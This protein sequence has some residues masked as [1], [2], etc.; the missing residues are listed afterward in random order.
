MYLRAYT[1]MAMH[2]MGVYLMGM[3]LKGVTKSVSD[4]WGGDV[5]SKGGC[6]VAL[7][8]GELHFL[9]RNAVPGI[10][11][12]NLGPASRLYRPTF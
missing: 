7:R 2:L 12:L 4:P 10:S 11:H 6:D 8:L 5:I 1:S 3:H 9:A